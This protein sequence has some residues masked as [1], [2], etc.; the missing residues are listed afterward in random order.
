MVLAFIGSQN[1]ISKEIVVGVERIK[2]S[3]FSF[4]LTPVVIPDL[5]SAKLALEYKFHPHFSVVLPV[6][7]KW[8]DYRWAIR[9]AAKTAGESDYMNYPQDWYDASKQPMIPGWNIDFSQ[10]KISSGLGVKYFP[11]S[12]ALTTA[13]YIKTLLMLGVER[14]NSYHG[15]GIQDS[16][17]VTHALTVGYSWVKGDWFSFGLEAGEEIMWHTNPIEGLPTIGFNGLMP[18]LQF[19]LGFT[20]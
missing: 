20:I 1:L 14:F 18:I 4:T 17:I 9:L 19:N 5:F 6:E 15:E 10:M 16:A 13:F 11:F 2:K 7:A 8:M 12:E 3:N